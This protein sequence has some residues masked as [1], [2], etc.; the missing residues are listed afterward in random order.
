MYEDKSTYIM[1][2][3]QNLD[4][5]RK[6]LIEITKI[7]NTDSYIPIESSI[8]IERERLINDLL[9]VLNEEISQVE[10]GV[11]NTNIGWKTPVL[12]SLRVEDQLL[13]ECAQ[14]IAWE[15]FPEQ[16]SKETRE[17]VLGIEND[18]F[19]D[20]S[21]VNILSDTERL[22][23]DSQKASAEMR[24]RSLIRNMRLCYVTKVR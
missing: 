9:S 18:P 21:M 20:P 11:L 16:F 23:I 13:S 14:R 8:A 7:R 15:L 3:E 2:R 10:T 4:D 6:R 12:S 22:V 24:Y 19:Y 5:I 17:H 1:D